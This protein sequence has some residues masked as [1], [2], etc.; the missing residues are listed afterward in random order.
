MTNPTLIIGVG[1]SGSKVLFWLKKDLLENFGSAEYYKP[2]F[3]VKLLLIDTASDISDPLGLDERDQLRLGGENVSERFGRLEGN[4]IQYIPTNSNPQKTH[5]L[6]NTLSA[7]P[8]NTPLPENL[9]HLSWLAPSAHFPDA[10][11]DL[12]NGAAQF[13]QLGRLALLQGLHYSGKNDDLYRK[14]QTLIDAVARP[15]DAGKPRQINIHIVGSFVGG[16]GSGIFIDIAALVR[17]VIEVAMGGNI[18]LQLTG[19]FALPRVFTTNPTQRMMS[20]TFNA[21]RELNRFMTASINNP[22]EIAWQQGMVYKLDKPLYEQVYLLDDVPVQGKAEHTAFPMLA[23][24]ISFFIDDQ[25]GR[26]YTQHITN[27]LNGYRTE[28]PYK[29]QPV[30]SAVRLKS[31]KRP[32]YHYRAVSSHNLALAYL[33][34]LLNVQSQ[35]SREADGVTYNSYFIGD[36]RSAASRANEI[37][38][39]DMPNFGNT[40]FIREINEAVSILPADREKRAGDYAYY[41]STLTQNFATLPATIENQLVNQKIQGLVEW[42]VSSVITEGR[43][44][45]EIINDINYVNQTLYGQ[46]RLGGQYAE[47]YG[48]FQQNVENARGTFYRELGRA[49]ELQLAVFQERVWNWVGITLNTAPNADRPGGLAAAKTALQQLIKYLDETIEFY[50]LVLG[51]MQDPASVEANVRNIHT[52]L[53]NWLDS[54]GGFN[55][56]MSNLFGS[57]KDRIQAWYVAETEYH[58]LQRNRRG[59]ERIISTLRVMKAFIVNTVLNEVEA[60]EVQ[61]VTG[62]ARI[63]VTSLYQGI[64]SSLNLE[65]YRYDLQD[66]ALGRIIARAGGDRP[67]TEP[68]QRL[69]DELVQNTTW[70]L[71][72]NRLTINI[73]I[74]PNLP[75]VT[76]QS[77]VNDP[78]QTYRLVSELVEEVADRYTRITET[79]TTTAMDQ[80]T[81]SD[82]ETSL[83][84]MN[85]TA[86]NRSPGQPPKEIRTFYVRAVTNTKQREN[87][88]NTLTNMGIPLKVSDGSGLMDSQNPYRVVIF[89]ADELLLHTNFNEWENTYTLYRSVLRGDARQGIEANSEAV[90]YNHLFKAEQKALDIESR[91]FHKNTAFNDTLDQLLVQFFENE[92]IF[93]LFLRLWVLNCIRRTTETVG[94]NGQV[95]VWEASVGDNTLGRA[96]FAPYVDET[97]IGMISRFVNKRTDLNGQMLNLKALSNQVEQY[98]RTNFYSDAERGQALIQR[99][100]LEIAQAKNASLLLEHQREMGAVLPAQFEDVVGKIFDAKA[101]DRASLAPFF[102]VKADKLLTLADMVMSDFGENTTDYQPLVSNVKAHLQMLQVVLPV[103]MDDLRNQFSI[104]LR[105]SIGSTPGDAS[106]PQQ[107]RGP[108][109]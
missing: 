51:H 66:G 107:R 6:F 14:L 101:E 82:V 103:V 17:H 34:Q 78:V 3:P 74:S 95:D 30:Y 2:D 65:N 45:S 48:D 20:R 75:P 73:R 32:I 22:I 29:G 99:C 81:M 19:F 88:T 42:E 84:A 47:R 53:T 5:D 43:T 64:M 44:P 15:V 12:V 41:A 97:T 91:Y 100:E 63:G 102:G 59:V 13:R 26:Q 35:E 93:K 89:S 27:N 56:F 33:R 50:G 24:A 7:T 39:L 109:A 72:N 10:A 21:W 67:N 85:N 9:A 54:L 77:N 80:I 108:R 86:F 46:M 23:E 104:A 4:E 16:T 11:K 8:R 58:H 90:I 79:D 18:A 69:V 68:D 61:L 60:M 1:G 25:S 83:R 55:T 87:L 70:N 31:W 38:L 96:S 94:V 52:D 57:I 28:Y 37:F 40:T 92:D 105:T 106:K 36:Q 49:E 98:L 71:Q 76:L 62:N